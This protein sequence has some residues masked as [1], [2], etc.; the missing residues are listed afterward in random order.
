MEIV[1][2]VIVL[3]KSLIAMVSNLP[4]RISLDFIMVEQVNVWEFHAPKIEMPLH[5]TGRKLKRLSVL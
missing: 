2:K 3:V 1:K 4:V 5:L